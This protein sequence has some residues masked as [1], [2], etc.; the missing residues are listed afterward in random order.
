[1]SIQNQ[2]NWNHNFMSF[3]AQDIYFT[4]L[5][6]FKSTYLNTFKF[7]IKILETVHIIFLQNTTIH[8]GHHKICFTRFGSPQ[9]NLSFFKFAHKTKNK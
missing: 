9:P 4:R 6:T 7:P 3:L 1:M 5:L 8:E 2:Q